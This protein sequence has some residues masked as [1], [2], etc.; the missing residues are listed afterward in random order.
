MYIAWT[1]GHFQIQ[2]ERP[3]LMTLWHRWT[4][5]RLRQC[6]AGHALDI[7]VLDALKA[8]DSV[9]STCTQNLRHTLEI[10]HLNPLNVS[11]VVCRVCSRWSNV[12]K[13]WKYKW[14]PKQYQ[15]ESSRSWNLIKLA[16]LAATCYIAASTG[17]CRVWL[18]RTRRHLIGA[19]FDQIHSHN[20]NQCWKYVEI[21]HLKY[22]PKIDIS[23][24]G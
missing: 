11:D 13:C 17:A 3:P 14:C 12:E 23:L 24:V 20:K 15:V 6:F 16:D 7:N 9:P 21:L 2:W 19:L 10:G 4:V 18:S 5:N 8:Q 22:L 1:F